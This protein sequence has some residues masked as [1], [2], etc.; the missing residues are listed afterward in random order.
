MHYKIEPLQDY[1]RAEVSDRKTAADT[2]DFIRALEAKVAEAG[3]TRVLICVRQ[4]RPIFKLQSHGIT[5]YFR[6]VAAN[7]ANRVA[8]ISDS[9]DM[10]SS[11]HYIEMLG[12]EQ[13]P[14][15]ARFAMK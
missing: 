6:N 7:P 12:R 4:S 9:D 1:V 2:H 5:E 8:L 15:C 11:Q 3:L 10:R 14:R 13:G